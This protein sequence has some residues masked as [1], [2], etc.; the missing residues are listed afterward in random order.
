MYN[1]LTVDRYLDIG[2]KI[3]FR[4]N[5]ELTLLVAKTEVGYTIA[6]NNQEIEIPLK[7]CK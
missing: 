2:D 3:N 5:E 1:V 4:V 6:V 7:E